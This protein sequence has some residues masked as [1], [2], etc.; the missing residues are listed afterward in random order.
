MPNSSA[1]LC[2]GLGR[3]WACSEGIRE[4]FTEVTEVEARKRMSLSDGK[5]KGR[6]VRQ[7]EPHELVSS[8]QRIRTFPSS[9]F[10]RLLWEVRKD[11][12]IRG[13]AQRGQR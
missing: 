9:W 4:G 8:A 3:R 5:G 13:V 6:A 7:R 10:M 12:S 1:L 11:W 2:W